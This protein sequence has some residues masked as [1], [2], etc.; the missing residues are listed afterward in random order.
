MIVFDFR[1]E[2]VDLINKYQSDLVS[3]DS[4]EKSKIWVEYIYDEKN[5]KK[6]TFRCRLCHAHYDEFGLEKRYKSA[7]AS[8]SGT[9]KSNKKENRKAITEHAKSPGHNNVIELLE[10][11]SSKR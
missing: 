3:I 1:N 6:S 5:P 8:E 10:K 2:W 4:I 7:F 9:L 11:R